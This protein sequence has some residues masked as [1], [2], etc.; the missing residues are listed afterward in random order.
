MKHRYT[1]EQIEYIRE[2]SPGRERTEIRDMVNNKYGLSVTTKSIAGVMYR[3]N[4][5]NRMQ[6]YNTRFEKGQKAW[7]KGKPFSPEGSSKS[8]FKKG[9]TNT[10]A[11][12]GSEH[13][14]DNRVMIKVDHPDVWVEKHRWL[15][16]Q[17]Y[18]KIP[19]GTA[20][21][22]KDGNKEN[23]TIENL[24]ATTRRAS[25]AVVRRNFPDHDPDLKVASHRLA[26]LDIVIKKSGA[27]I[28]GIKNANNIG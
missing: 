10:R 4:I 27:E 8:W 21:S 12:I 7:N 2:I 5:K 3:N 19:E 24:F 17:H 23:V 13:L 18:G 6:G 28:G 20:I 22:F 15:W 9:H 25:T 26:E 1:K 11:P 16:E 14:K